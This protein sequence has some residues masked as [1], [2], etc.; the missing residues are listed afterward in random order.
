MFFEYLVLIR[1]KHEHGWATMCWFDVSARVNNIHDIRSNPAQ[2]VRR[3]SVIC[4]SRIQT[5]V[6]S[7]Y[8][9]V[10]VPS[11]HNSEY[12]ISSN[13][14]KLLERT[15]LLSES[16]SVNLMTV[17]KE[18]TEQL[19]M[20]IRGLTFPPN[21]LPENILPMAKLE[22]AFLLSKECVSFWTEYNTLQNMRDHTKDN[23]VFIAIQV[24]FKL[25]Q[26][27]LNKILVWMQCCI[28]RISVPHPTKSDIQLSTGNP[29]LVET[30]MF[31]YQEIF[32]GC[33]KAIKR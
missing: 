23:T 21:Q 26:L 1:L 22:L 9:E 2:A 33:V 14:S 4:S 13:E 16:K 20:R 18:I 7:N 30:L 11:E 29:F 17:P 25:K 31:Y 28:G 5:E 15:H 12:G 10:S 3:D 6:I 19:K 32:T 27:K 24:R 8:N